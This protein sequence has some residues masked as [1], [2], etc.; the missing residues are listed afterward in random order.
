MPGFLKAPVLFFPQIFACLLL[1]VASSAFANAEAVSNGL[2]ASPSSSIQITLS[3]QADTAIRLEARAAP[4]RQILEAIADKTS[5]QIHYSV[6]PEE[7]VTATCAGRTISGLL[8]CLL[9]SRVDR[10]YRYPRPGAARLNAAKSSVVRPY[11]DNPGITKPLKILAQNAFTQPEEIWLLATNLPV[12]PGTTN[13]PTSAKEPEIPAM[14]VQTPE[15]RAQIEAILKQAASKNSEE[16]TGALQNLGLIGDKDNPD[17]RKAL[18]DA[19]TDKN[20]DIRAQAISSLIQREGD[21]AIQEAQRALSDKDV[22]VRIA[23][24]DKVYGDIGLLQQAMQ[25]SSSEVRDMAAAKLDHL[26][27]K[28]DR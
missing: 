13:T 19:L 21:G 24:I 16:R 23:V 27:R 14:P 12:K 18:E 2:Q 1:L 4:L 15:E 10:V 22:N 5:A 11:L 25:D 17:I 8:E 9:G 7:P 6:L 20:A 28:Q 26:A 3:R